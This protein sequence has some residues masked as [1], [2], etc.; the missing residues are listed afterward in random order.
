MKLELITKFIKLCD[1]LDERESKYNPFYIFFL[2]N[3]NI[4][5]ETPPDEIHI[6]TIAQTLSEESNLSIDEINELMDRVVSVSNSIAETNDK[7]I[8]LID[9]DEYQDEFLEYL[10][11][12]IKPVLMS[13][14]DQ[15]DE[16]RE[17]FN[18]EAEFILQ[19]ADELMEFP[20]DWR[21]VDLDEEM[22][23]DPTSNPYDLG[24]EL[25]TMK[26][27][28]SDLNASI[29]RDIY[30]DI[31]YFWNYFSSLFASTQVMDMLRRE[32]FLER[33]GF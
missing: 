8:P 5:M 12:E 28:A 13:Y 4:W 14:E 22:E 21:E 23:E 26:L 2:L 24:Y 7:Y 15:V 31:D 6:R 1:W 10:G 25:G 33:N 3:R 19:E 29:N 9:T 16:I 30:S 32:R 17:I 18:G 27:L 11:E 20:F